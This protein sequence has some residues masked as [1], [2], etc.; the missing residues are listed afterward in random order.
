MSREERIVPALMVA[1]ATTPLPFPAYARDTAKTAT[2]PRIHPSIQVLEYRRIAVSEVREPSPQG[3]V[4]SR[5]DAREAVAAGAPGFHR[6]RVLELR[7]ALL[8]RP[9]TAL[10]EAIAQKLE[11]L[12]HGV[13]DARLGRVENQLG[14]LDPLRNFAELLFG[15]LPTSTQDHESSSPGDSHAQALAE[16]DVNVSAHPALIIQSQVE[17]RSATSRS[18][19]VP[20]GPPTPAAMPS[21]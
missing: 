2:H 12:G 11:A 20:A 21:S 19:S 4:E 15:F 6:R 16:P 8:A 9:S 14:L 1:A 18:G 13:H 5:D 10:R 7:Q 3:R 17:F